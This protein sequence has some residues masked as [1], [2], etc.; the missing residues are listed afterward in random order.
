[1]KNIV[2]AAVIAS[3]ILVAQ[4]DTT[5]AGA[6]SNG[7]RIPDFSYCGY[8]A[9][10]VSIPEV[11]GGVTISPREECRMMKLGGTLINTGEP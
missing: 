10:G 4:P 1:M 3:L 7:D 11:A 5:I 6:E 2:A 9:G 8:R